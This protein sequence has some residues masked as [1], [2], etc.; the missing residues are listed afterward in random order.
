M[1]HQTQCLK[2]TGAGVSSSNDM[3]L[4][5]GFLVKLSRSGSSKLGSALAINLPGC[6][7]RYAP[8]ETVSTYRTCRWRHCQIIKVA[9]S[10][11]YSLWC[12]SRIY[13]SVYDPP[14]FSSEA[15]SQE[16]YE[17]RNPSLFWVRVW[18]NRA[19][20][21]LMSQSGLEDVSF[22]FHVVIE[23]HTFSAS[24]CKRR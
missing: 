22:V 13:T 15:P 18:P 21:E 5:R 23:L 20:L 19:H 3:S 16:L 2:Q 11:T 7:W 12:S 24:P 17:S 8:E 1:Y 9:I 10:K 4:S 14:R 6:N